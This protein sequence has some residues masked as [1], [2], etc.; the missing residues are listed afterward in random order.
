MCTDSDF[1]GCQRTRKSTSGGV[2]C[3]GSHFLKGWSS[4]QQ[5]VTRSSAEAELV[6]PRLDPPGEGER[7]GDSAILGADLGV[8]EGEEVD[9]L[10][11]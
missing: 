10:D 8:S 7:V 3:I 2:I 1:A 6:A 11:L 5:S 4:T 9:H